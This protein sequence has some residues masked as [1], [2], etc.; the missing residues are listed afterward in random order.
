MRLRFVNE[1][2]IHRM[3]IQSGS[4]VVSEIGV[5]AIAAA[6]VPPR[7]K[8]SNYP[9]V[10]AA[11]VAG[12]TKRQL[13]DFF[14]LKNFGVNLTS[15]APGAIS[16]LQ[17]RHK[18]Q[19]EFVYVLEGE[20][21]LVSGSTETRLEAGMCAGFRAGGDSHH[22]ENRSGEP[23]TY[24]EI[25]D[26]TAGDEATYPHDDLLAVLGPAGWEFRHKDGSPY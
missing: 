9:P 2:N 8:P 16:A 17:H 5:R 26:R 1:Y 21:W 23:A 13:G 20:L 18:L 15:L 7:T 25:G 4:C 10:F 6:S 11:R 12:R 14:G 19:D 22:L 3:E 24:L